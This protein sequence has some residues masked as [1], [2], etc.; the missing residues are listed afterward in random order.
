MVKVNKLKQEKLFG[1]NIVL[2]PLKKSHESRAL[3]IGS[4]V[5]DPLFRVL[6]PGSS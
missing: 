5:K 2:G 6:D 4:W 1:P 3:C